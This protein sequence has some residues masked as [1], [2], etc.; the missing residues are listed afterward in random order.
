MGC[1]NLV[2]I[3]TAFSYSSHGKRLGPA[4]IKIFQRRHHEDYVRGLDQFGCDCL[5]LVIFERDSEL[6][7]N[8]DGARRR[9]NPADSI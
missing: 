9:P 2:L 6:R 5:W 8:H 4:S 3:R 1:G 7:R